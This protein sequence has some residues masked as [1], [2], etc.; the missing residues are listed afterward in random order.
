MDPSFDAGRSSTLAW[1]PCDGLRDELL[2][3]ADACEHGWLSC[4]AH[5]LLREPMAALEALTRSSAN[6]NTATASTENAGRCGLRRCSQA[7]PWAVVFF[8]SVADSPRRWRLEAQ[9]VPTSLMV[10]STLAFGRAG[11]DLLG[12]AVATPTDAHAPTCSCSQL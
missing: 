5:L 8:R 9:A 10:S 11:C 1:Q 7:D 6:A 12:L 2:P 3:Y 4:V